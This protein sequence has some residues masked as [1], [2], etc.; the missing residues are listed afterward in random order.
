VSVGVRVEVAVG[1]CVGVGVSVTQWP[2]GLSH[3]ALGISSQ[4][5]QFPGTGGGAQAN[6]PHWQHSC[7]ALREESRDET[8]TNSAAHARNPRRR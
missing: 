4:P 3:T 7:A 6:S 2:V 8:R 1:V 5:P